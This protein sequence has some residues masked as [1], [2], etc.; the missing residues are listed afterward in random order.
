MPFHRC[1]DHVDLV[2][3]LKRS[4]AA[5]LQRGGARQHD[6]GGIFLVS[7]DNTGQ[8]VGETGAGGNQANSG[9]AII[10][11]PGMRHHGRGLFMPDIDEFDT[12]FVKAVVYAIDVATGKGKNRTD[13]LHLFQILGHHVSTVQ[14]SHLTLL[15][16][17]VLRR[18]P[19]QKSPVFQNEKQGFV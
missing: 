8:C 7:I 2:D 5:V 3:F 16:I 14:F 1:F 13:F 11:G 12:V 18:S 17:S 4:Q 19:Q 6:H 9:A 10:N 15:L